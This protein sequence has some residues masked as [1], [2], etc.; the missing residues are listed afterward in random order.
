MMKSVQRTKDGMDSLVDHAR[1][2]VVGATDRLERGVES[3][4]GRLVDHAHVAGDYI[5]DEVEAASRGA[6][7][8]LHRAARAVSRGYSRARSDLSRVATAS[9]DYVAENP[10]K[11]LLIAASVGFLLGMAVGRRRR[12]A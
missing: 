10:G 9:T 3:A 8:R 11:A 5:R 2:A 6:H 12:C 1:E 7:R 4:A